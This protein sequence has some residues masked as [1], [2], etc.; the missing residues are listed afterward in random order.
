MKESIYNELDEIVVNEIISR[1][2]QKNE[3]LSPEEYVKIVEGIMG[4]R[5]DA[6][7]R[8]L[9][10]SFCESAYILRE[11]YIENGRKA[12]DFEDELDSIYVKLNECML[13]FSCMTVREYKDYLKDKVQTELKLLREERLEKNAYLNGEWTNK[14]D[15]LPN[16][17]AQPKNN[18]SMVK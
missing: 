15:K 6:Y 3:R 12:Q 2:N 10:L 8:L 14:V 1:R 18:R 13:N 16:H 17:K 7:D 4:G 9:Y 5:T 11:D